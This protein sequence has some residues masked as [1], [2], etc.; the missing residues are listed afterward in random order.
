LLE[1]GAEVCCPR[2]VLGAGAC[3]AGDDGAGAGA[4]DDAGSGVGSGVA[5][6]AG[7]GVGCGAADDGGGAAEEAGGA[8]DVGELLLLLPVPDAC[9][10]TRDQYSP[11]SPA[12]RK[13][14]PLN[15]LV[16]ILL[17]AVEIEG[18]RQG[19]QRKES[20]QPRVAQHVWWCGVCKRERADVV[21]VPCGPF[22]EV[23]R[24]TK[25]VSAPN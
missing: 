3:D 13:R 12:I 10:W 8:A 5:E 17:H 23:T 16:D 4:A 18:R 24:F 20:Q 22:A 9:L 2:V 7:V 14:L 11:A 15:A 19:Q 6:G 25:T 21:E 1:R